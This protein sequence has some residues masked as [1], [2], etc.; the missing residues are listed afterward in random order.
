[1]SENEP[2]AKKGLGGC[3]IAAIVVAVVFSIGIVALV[4]LGMRSPI[5]KKAL[6]TMTVWKTVMENATHGPGTAELK[7]SLCKQSI[8]VVD[9]D[10]ARA[11]LKGADFPGDPLKILVSDARFEILCDPGA[12]G[13]SITCSQVA[14]AWLQAVK[15]TS[16]NFEVMVSNKQTQQT[17]GACNRVY[18]AAGEDIG[19]GHFKH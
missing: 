14:E 2:Q 19:V 1:M 12:N 16:G 13:S 5:A 15:T 18:S 8:L 17:V 6:A 10:D 3:L 4:V 7:R 9:L 11:R